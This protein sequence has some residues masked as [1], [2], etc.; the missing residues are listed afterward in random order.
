M[1]KLIYLLHVRILSV[2]VVCV[3]CFA[4]FLLGCTGNT[5]VNTCPAVADLL[6]ART[7]FLDPFFVEIVQAFRLEFAIN[8]CGSHTHTEGQYV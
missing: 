4:D 3:V 5:L 2:A 8:E 6:R 1:F 7:I